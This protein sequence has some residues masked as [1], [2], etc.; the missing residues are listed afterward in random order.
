MTF[1]IIDP[2]D[3]I[4]RAWAS[5]FPDLFV[6]IESMPTELRE[7]LR[8]PEDL[9][10]VQTEAY[11]KYRLDADEFFDRLGAWSVA[12][13]PSSTPRIITNQPADAGTTDAAPNAFAAEATS[14]R[15]VPYYS[16]FQA[17]GQTEP[18][19]QLLRPFVPFSTNDER[20][21]LQAFMLASS[22]IANYGQMTAYTVAT[23]N[24]DGPATV[25]ATIES[26]SRIAATI[27]PLDLAGSQVIY[28]DMQFV[29]VA[30]GLLYLR[31][32]YVKS[33]STPQASYRFMLASYNGNASF[34]STIEEAIG[35]LFPGFRTDIGDV[36]GSGGEPAD[37]VDPDDPQDPAVE[38]TVPGTG[39]PAELLAQAQV[40]FEQ[41]DA[42]LPDFA[43]YDELNRQARQLIQDA[44]AA[45]AATG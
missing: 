13:A 26:D 43:R 38:P 12:Q 16:V 23:P 22:D 9:F 5:A 11:S 44:V 34:G 31:P 24:V 7:H 14:A 20:K 15:F 41:A 35:N 1:Y 29:P 28:G 39:T 37:P 2:E 4:I 10:R 33:D 45:L 36:V 6:S 17:P 3:P 8:Y 40:L 25:A 19:F 30:G 21:E 32:L 18:S 42:A 27:T